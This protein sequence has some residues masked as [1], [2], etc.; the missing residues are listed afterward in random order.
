MSLIRVFQTIDNDVWS[1]TFV[2][3]PSHLSEGDKKLMRQF[4]EPEV[5][6][7]GTFLA[8]TDNEFTLPTKK[9]RLRSDFPFTESFDSRDAD[10]EENTKTKVEGYR[11]AIVTRMTTAFTTLRAQED[12][13]T[14][15]LTYNV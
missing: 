1:V 6:M 8:S 10:F 3:D 14:S 2:V 12:T 7:G 9:A 4:G 5:E 13:F 11:A 15:E